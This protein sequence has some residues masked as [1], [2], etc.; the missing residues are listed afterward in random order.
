MQQSILFA[1]GW[2]VLGLLYYRSL[3]RKG[4]SFYREIAA[5]LKQAQHATQ[6]WHSLQRDFNYE[7]DRIKKV[8]EEG[9]VLDEHMIHRLLKQNEVYSKQ[10]VSL[11]SVLGMYQ[12]N[13]SAVAE[14]FEV[15]LSYMPDVPV[16]RQLKPYTEHLRNTVSLLTDIVIDYAEIGDMMGQILKL[17]PC[18]VYC[19]GVEFMPV[20]QKNGDN[21]LRLFYKIF[22]VQGDSPHYVCGGLLWGNPFN[23]RKSEGFLWLCE[24][25][26]TE[27]QLECA[28]VDCAVFLKQ[29]KLLPDGTK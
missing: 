23:E 25:I 6:R 8:Y 9:K 21:E 22:S 7:F 14:S 3:K 19:E 17:L 13:A 29:N 26:T 1:I 20:L 28:I 15:L 4:Q 12:R 24:N 5:Y 10:N 16:I 27:Y 11:R 18:Y 2:L